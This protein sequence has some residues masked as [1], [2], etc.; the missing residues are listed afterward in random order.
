[1]DDEPTK[2]FLFYVRRI[3]PA[4]GRNDL[5]AL[6][7][8]TPPVDIIISAGRGREEIVEQAGFVRKFDFADD[9]GLSRRLYESVPVAP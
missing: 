3:I 2:V 5:P 7:R 4:I 8:A 9:D 6:A 1:M